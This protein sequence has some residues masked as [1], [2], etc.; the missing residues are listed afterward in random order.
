MVPTRTRRSGCGRC[1]PG[2]HSQRQH[3][4]MTSAFRMMSPVRAEIGPVRA[5][6]ATGQLP[7]TVAPRVR[8]A[9]TAFDPISEASATAGDSARLER[10]RGR[11]GPCES[12]RARSTRKA[13]RGGARAVCVE[14]VRAV[15]ECIGR[16]A[17]PSS[18]FPARATV[19]PCL[20]DLQTH[21]PIREGSCRSSR[22]HSQ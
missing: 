10:V 12:V 22:T 18:Q 2:S 15:T 13:I 3:V 4:N 21:G 7:L 5:G 19:A 6:G 1:K 16:R 8:F 9:F 14:A 11:P 20:A 17:G